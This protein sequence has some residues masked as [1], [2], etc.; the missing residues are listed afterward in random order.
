MRARTMKRLADDNAVVKMQKNDLTCL[1]DARF[2]LE[3]LP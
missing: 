2:R 3:R 1:S